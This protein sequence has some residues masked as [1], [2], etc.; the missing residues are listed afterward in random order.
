FLTL[1]GAEVTFCGG[2]RSRVPNARGALRLCLAL[3]GP[4]EPLAGPQER[5]VS[6]GSG[7]AQ[8]GEGGRVGHAQ[9]QSSPAA[10]PRGCGA[11]PQG[12][13]RGDRHSPPRARP[14][15]RARRSRPGAAPGSARPAAELQPPGAGDFRGGGCIFHQGRGSLLDR[16]Q[17][18]LYRDVM[19]ENYETVI[20]LVAGY[21]A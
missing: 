11:G 12:L 5:F 17:R 2:I 6:P 14:G 1:P 20:F 9:R 19:Q 10:A 15:P 18:A 13:C 8:I 16:T 7:H 4:L 3:A 21:S